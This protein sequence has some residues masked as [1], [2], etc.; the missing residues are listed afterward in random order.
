MADPARQ[1][2]VLDYVDHEGLVYWEVSARTGHKVE[3]LL[4]A[5]AWGLQTHTHPGVVRDS[6][7]AY[8]HGKTLTGALLSWQD[9]EIRSM[10]ERAAL[11]SAAKQ[12]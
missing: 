12:G 2:D 9:P 4:L 5:L 11:R 10:A 7:Q 1:A 8:V 3:E 6:R